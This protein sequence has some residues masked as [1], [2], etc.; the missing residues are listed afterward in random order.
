MLPIV[1]AIVNDPIENGFVNSIERPGGNITGLAGLG[2]E[3]IGKQL[4]ILRE[5]IPRISRVAILWSPANPHGGRSLK[6]IE[7]LGRSLRLE[8]VSRVMTGP[9]D[10]ESAFHFANTKNA[11]AIVLDRGRFVAFHQ[12]QIIELAVKSRLPAIYANTRHVKAGGLMTYTYDRKALYRHAAEYID[13]I[14]KGA[15]PADLP[16]E[17]PKRF[18]F[19]I[20]LKIAK[21]LGLTIPQRVLARA[22]ELIK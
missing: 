18:E 21:Q 7:T 1:T 19:V 2:P 6:D 17:T 4:E 14:L 5:V 16:M 15:K 3:K 9:N 8:I 11:D 22:D 13:K 12:K 20:N 10:I